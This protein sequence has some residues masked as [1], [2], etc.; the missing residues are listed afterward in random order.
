MS[1]YNE[2]IKIIQDSYGLS[3][4]ETIKLLKQNKYNLVETILNIETNSYKN[5]KNIDIE[6]ENDDF[7][8]KL[9]TDNPKYQKKYRDIVDD[10]DSILIKSKVKK[11]ISDVENEYFTKRE[12]EGNLNKIKLL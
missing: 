5:E 1:F 7:N 3:K 2:D 6:S 12:K 10:K 11:K 4:K 9:Y 8:P